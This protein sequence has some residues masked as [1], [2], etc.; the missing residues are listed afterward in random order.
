[1]LNVCVLCLVR[2][3]CLPMN[4]SFTLQINESGLLFSNKVTR[5]LANRQ[6]PVFFTS[7]FQCVECMTDS[8]INILFRPYTGN[9]TCG[10]SDPNYK[11]FFYTEYRVN[12]CTQLAWSTHG[13]PEYKISRYNL[14]H[15][16]CAADG[17][18]A[19]YRLEFELQSC[20]LGNGEHY[21]WSTYH[22]C[23]FSKFILLVRK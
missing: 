7:W 10:T 6:C 20:Y 12:N 4:C 17:R 2:G 11:T 9:L 19:A 22:S 14:I 3:C 23:C 21:S 15:T 5:V 1:M 18:T 16:L 8:L 13:S